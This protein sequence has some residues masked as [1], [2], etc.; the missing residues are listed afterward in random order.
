MYIPVHEKLYCILARVLKVAVSAT[1]ISPFL[2]HL[3]ADLRRATGQVTLLLVLGV[4]GRV[5]VTAVRASVTVE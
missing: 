1:A 5:S 3:V 2:G 4:L